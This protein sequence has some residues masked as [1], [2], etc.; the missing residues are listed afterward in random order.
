MEV[1]LLEVRLIEVW[2]IEGSGSAYI[3]NS[4]SA[5]SG[6]LPSLYISPDS[7]ACRLNTKILLTPTGSLR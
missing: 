3:G 5:T 6:Y 7:S 2:L 4:G 1:L